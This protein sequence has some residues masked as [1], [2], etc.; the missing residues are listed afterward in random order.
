VTAASDRAAAAEIAD[1]L[2]ANLVD[3]DIAKDARRGLV[4]AVARLHEAVR[5]R[6]RQRAELDSLIDLVARMER[7]A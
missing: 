6:A 7:D 4:A 5:L 3:D 2:R 1:R